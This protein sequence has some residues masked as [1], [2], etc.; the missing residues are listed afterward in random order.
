MTSRPR[1]LRARAGPSRALHPRE[2]RL[3]PSGG[4]D[5]ASL[6]PRG[7]A[8]RRA[9]PAGRP[10]NCS[11]VRTRLRGDF[12]KVQPSPTAAAKAAAFPGGEGEGRRAPGRSHARRE[13][14]VE[15]TARAA[16][17]RA[18]SERRR[19]VVSHFISIDQRQSSCKFN[20]FVWWIEA[21]FRRSISLYS[22]LST[23]AS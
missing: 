22:S 5:A 8:V 11:A 19:C 21:L 15:L 7:S 3:A 14:G 13:P 17:E 4:E 20:H 23:A 16:C 1:P 6:A 9:S 12:G 10:W 2:G 18:A